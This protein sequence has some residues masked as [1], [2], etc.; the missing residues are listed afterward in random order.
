MYDFSQIETAVQSFF[1]AVPQSIFVIP[2]APPVPA[3]DQEFDLGDGNCAIFT[4]FNNLVFQ[5]YRPR[6]EV[7]LHS[8]N[9]FPGQQ[10]V[11][12]LGINGAGKE[13]RASAWQGR[14]GFGIITVADY[15]A[16]ISLRTAVLAILPALQPC[17]VPD[18]SAIAT[19]GV[20]GLLQ[21]HQV[22]MIQPTNLSTTIVLQDGY[23][24]S[25][26]NCLCTFSVKATAWPGGTN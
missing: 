20:N 22:G 2:P 26:I 5:K 3:T 18:G 15:P 4:A 13:L 8:V 7:L 21:F 12:N 16:H 10:V 25:D 23:Y 11:T 14:M 24:R 1:V 9:E 6:V 19:S 17:V